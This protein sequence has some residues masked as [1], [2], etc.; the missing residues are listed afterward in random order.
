MDTAG[1][2][3]VRVVVAEPLGV[4]AEKVHEVFREIVGDG[5]E[6]VVYES[7]PAGEE[8]LIERA[9]G[10]DVLVIVSARVS[11]RVLHETGVRMVAVAFTGV[12]HVDL[13]AARRL[14]VVVSNVPGY[15][16][17]AVAELVVGMVLAAA[18]K[19]VLADG[20]VRRGGWREELEP[21]FEVQGSTWGLVGFGRIGRRVAELAAA[22]GAHLLVYDRSPWVGEKRALIERLGARIAGSLD[23]VFVR[24]RIVS[25]H[26][27]L[28]RETR[29]LIRY[30]HLKMMPRGAILVNVSRGGVIRE[31][32]LLRFLR[33]RQDVTACL[34]V[35]EV[36]PLPR[37]HP[38]TELPNVILT[39]HIGFY[40]VEALER[41]LRETMLNIRA[42]LENR[43]RN[44]VVS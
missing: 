27:P 43:P 4:P 8:E 18:R 21:G 29:H 14:G 22:L 37:G 11:E 31:D 5:H 6:L 32:D 25:I 10:A 44:L 41:R 38:L 34:D 16:T 30:E 15:A 20:L 12:D 3:M 9:R 39:P 23:E 33:E 7:R 2:V 26:V 17:E 24:S 28:T 35:Y 19:L 36:E 13:E 40:T 42:F 1:L